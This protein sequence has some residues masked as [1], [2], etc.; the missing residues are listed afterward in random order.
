MKKIAYM[1]LAMA[2]AC[3]CQI[4]D[5]RDSRRNEYRL[6]QFAEQMMWTFIY[7]P[8]SV[9]NS[10]IDS[11]KE[12][13]GIASKISSNVWEFDI[14]EIPG[15][16]TIVEYIGKDEQGNDIFNISTNGTVSN[17]YYRGET[18]R[19]HKALMTLSPDSVTLV[20]PDE[21]RGTGSVK[22]EGLITI[23]IYRD[24]EK[25]D[26]VEI[27]LGKDGSMMTSSLDEA[28]YE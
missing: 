8:A 4:D 28:Y 9:V 6:K 1:I 14:Q 22:G 20:E 17:K 15:C 11:G 13:E 26:F 19:I 25:V 27:H 16:K 18:T 23:D 5:G 12:D 21:F 7:R 2:L 3:S 24:S 10:M